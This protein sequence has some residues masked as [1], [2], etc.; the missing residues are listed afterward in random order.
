MLFPPPLTLLL[1][2]LLLLLLVTRSFP[3]ILKNYTGEYQPYELS[4]ACA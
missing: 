4:A 3:K 2:L 1:L